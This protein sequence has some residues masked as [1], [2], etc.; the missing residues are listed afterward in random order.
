MPYAILDLDGDQNVDI[1]AASPAGIVVRFGSVQGQFAA[2]YEAAMEIPWGPPA[3]SDVSGDGRADAVVPVWSGVMLFEGQGERS[4]APVAFTQYLAA[5][6]G[7]TRYLPIRPGG[8]FPGDDIISITADKDAVSL[9]VWPRNPYDQPVSTS[10]VAPALN[11]L[12]G[13]IP[14]ANLFGGDPRLGESFVM[15]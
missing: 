9:F 8:D 12:S 2:S 1:L 6:L 4:L 3:F 14:V 5:S 15:A 11:Q 10:F 13:R 7:G